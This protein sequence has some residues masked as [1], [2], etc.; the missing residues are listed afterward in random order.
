MRE[1]W[2][3]IIFSVALVVISYLS[4]TADKYER[5]AELKKRGVINHIDNVVCV[6]GSPDMQ[7]LMMSIYM[8][9][10][11]ISVDEI[12]SIPLDRV[13]LA[14]TFRINELRVTDRLAGHPLVRPPW[15]KRIWARAYFLCKMKTNHYLSI[16]LSDP[17]DNVCN[18][19]FLTDSQ[20]AANNFAAGLN[21]HIGT[22]LCIDN[23]LKFS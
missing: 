12:L 7:G 22:V 16:E 19:L 1:I 2:K 9:S 10:D 4:N 21:H 3:L 6:K 13:K 8:Y 11:K 5:K 14:Q 15:F 23:G 20:K 18:I 17:K